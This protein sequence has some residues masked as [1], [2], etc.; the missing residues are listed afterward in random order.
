MATG[1]FFLARR[2]VWFWDNRHGGPSRAF[3][4]YSSS[5]GVVRRLVVAWCSN[6][7]QIM[8]IFTICIHFTYADIYHISRYM[9]I[10]IRVRVCDWVITSNFH[11]FSIEPQAAWLTCPAPDGPAMPRPL[12]IPHTPC[13]PFTAL[14]GRAALHNLHCFRFPHNYYLYKMYKLIKRKGHCSCLLPFAFC[15]LHLVLPWPLL[16]PL[17]K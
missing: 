17:N 12:L 5:K 10:H 7:D 13:T 2:S 15:L 11:S 16:R 8:T 4:C 6:L 1:Y 9:Y 14:S 3:E